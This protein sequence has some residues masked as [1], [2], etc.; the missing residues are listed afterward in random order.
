MQAAFGY[1]RGTIVTATNGR[2]I[3]TEMLGCR[4]DGI[5][6]CQIRALIALHLSDSHD[7]AEIGVFTRPFD[8]PPPS[9]IAGDIHHGGEGPVKAAGR[10]LP[11]RNS[12]SGFPLFGFPAG[13]DCERDREDCPVTVDHIHR[14]KQRDFQAAFFHRDALQFAQGFCTRHMKIGADSAGPD[15]VIFFRREFGIEIFGTAASGLS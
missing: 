8:N 11:G 15:P 12:G 13:S 5:A 7:A 2:A 9:R 10:S 14:E 3:G 1:V 6:G 4:H